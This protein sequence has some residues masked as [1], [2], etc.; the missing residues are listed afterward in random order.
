M[1]RTR[2]RETGVKKTTKKT[3]EEI[4]KIERHKAYNIIKRR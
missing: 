3:G 1:K 4:Q 2:K